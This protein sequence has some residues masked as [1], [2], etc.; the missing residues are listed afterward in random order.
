MHVSDSL[1]WTL[2]GLLGLVGCWIIVLNFSA[3]FLWYV[4]RQHHSVIPLIGGCLAGMAMLVCPLPR[5][6][7]LAWLPMVVDL[8]CL[9][10]VIGFIYSVVVLKCFKR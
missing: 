2:A 7:R 8:G 6:M 5:V 3:V 10:S 9:Y 1:R 4:R